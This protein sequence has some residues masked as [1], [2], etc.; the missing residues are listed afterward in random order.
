MKVLLKKRDS[1]KNRRI[2]NLSLRFIY[3][4]NGQRKSKYHPFNGLNKKH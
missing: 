1:E 4:N 3:D 2:L